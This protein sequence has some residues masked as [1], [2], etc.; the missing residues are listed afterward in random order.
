MTTTHVSDT[1][2]TLSEALMNHPL[3]AVDL[4]GD[5][6]ETTPIYDALTVDRADPFN[7]LR[8]LGVRITTAS[9]HCDAIMRGTTPPAPADVIEEVAS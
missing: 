4:P 6:T 7:E 2:T 5:T 9:E 8:S 1:S 3:Y